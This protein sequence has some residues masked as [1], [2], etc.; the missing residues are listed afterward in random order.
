MEQSGEGMEVVCVCVCVHA[1]TPGG[2]GGGGVEGKRKRGS[3]RVS[4]LI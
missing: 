3:L 1:R 2:E 4:K